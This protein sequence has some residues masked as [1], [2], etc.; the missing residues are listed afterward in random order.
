MKRSRSALFV[1]STLLSVLPLANAI[2]EQSSAPA[3]E[4]IVVTAQRTEENIQ[5]TPVSITAFSADDV[6]K[7]QI[8]NAKDL[9]QVAP[10]VLIKPVSGG[11]GGITPFIRGGGVSDGANITSEAEVGIYIDGVYQ[12]RSAASFIESLDIERIE[13]LRGPQG[14]LYGRNSSAGALKFISRLPGEELR[15]KNEFGVGIWNE[16]YDK[17][18]VSGPL[19]EDGSLRGGLSGMYRDRDG[20]RQDNVT[21][22]QKVGA[23]EFQGLQGDLYYDGGNHTARLKLFYTDYD[24][25][26][27]YASALD[28]FAMTGSY[29]DFPYASGDIDKLLSPY[30]SYTTDTQYGGSLEIST[31]ISDTLT[32]TSITSFTTLQ[33]DWAVGFSGGVASSALGIPSS[34]YLE[35]F[36]RESVSDQDSFTQEFQFQG[37]AFDEFM[38]YVAG[39][40]FFRESGTQNVDS[41]IFF[42]PSYTDFDITTKSY[43]A[44]GQMNFY[45]TNELSLIVGGRYTEDKKEMDANVSGTTV[46]ADDSFNKFTPKVA[47]EYQP[48]DTTLLFASYT[49][50][51]KAGGYNSLASSAEALGTAFDMQEL[52]AYEVGYKSDWM[53]SRLRFNLAAFFNEYTN[54]QQQSVTNEGVFITENYDAEHK[55]VEVELSFQA[56]EGLYL[57]ANGV[58]QDS[59][60][61]DT[62][63]S[64]GQSSGSLLGNQLT[65]V[66]D[67][68]FALGF[69]YSYDIGPG[70]LGLGANVNKR[71]DLYSTA[72]NVEIGHLKPV[73]LV[74]AYL[75]YKVGN[76]KV[77]L[78][79]KNL[80]DEKYWF[81][82]FG[83][84][85]VQPRF[86]ADPM[87]WKLGVSYEY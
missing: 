9:S 62:S 78:A 15:V 1:N 46:S 53:A 24:S 37:S 57:W 55:G 26:G 66:F 65:N 58:Y 10:N 13:V 49:E 21:R 2:A 83:F 4:N 75:S 28:P 82:G 85:V 86:M 43:A 47:L 79:G 60:Y 23:E 39:L 42:G 18:T 16:V 3:L 44:F 14:T 87:T 11:S 34:D 41:V 38:S 61:T 51:F 32:L 35:L 31:D 84:S 72:D 27:L 20:G 36:E 5:S 22:N 40:Y 6:E 54:L 64:G 73:T 29:E 12:P 30:A 81:T 69:D 7:F 48:N 77:N 76:W 70:T 8:D 50:G 74:D 17:F 67:Y 25:D 45:L 68:Q 33:D 56:T 59:E 52:S 71:D 19:S 63:A 80:T